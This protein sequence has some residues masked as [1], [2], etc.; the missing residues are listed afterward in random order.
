[1]PLFCRFAWDHG[2]ARE[3]VDYT[4]ADPSDVDE[5]RRISVALRNLSA[6]FFADPVQDCD[7]ASVTP[8]RSIGETVL[9]VAS[10]F[11][12]QPLC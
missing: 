8:E 5:P 6:E 7:D 1:M 12:G 3:G 9:Q 10:T 4:S 2:I 11:T